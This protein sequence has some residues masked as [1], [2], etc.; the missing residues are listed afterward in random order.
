MGKPFDIYKAAIFNGKQEFEEPGKTGE[1]GVSGSGVSKGYL[2][3]D[4]SFQESMHR[5]Y[6]MTGDLGFID[7][8]G[9]RIR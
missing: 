2:K 7:K 9:F 1:I 6:F 3:D 4:N 8:E 5:D